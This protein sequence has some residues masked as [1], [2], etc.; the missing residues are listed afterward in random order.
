MKRTILRLASALVVFAAVLAVV[1]V[2]PFRTVKAHHG[3]SARTLVGD[4][5]WTEF[6]LE[7]ETTGVPFWSSTALVHF[8]GNGNFTGSDVYYVEDG[9][10]DGP[11]TEAGTYTVNSA[12]TVTIS[13][14]WES[15]S[16][17]DHGVIVGSNGSEVIAEE[18]SDGSD[19][20]GHVDIKQIADWQ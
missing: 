12:C 16:Y 20:T 13:Y 1:A 2:H 14:T 6:G 19:T 10:L 17:T 3:C 4:Y 18:S 5:G 8:D 11:S 7:P 15:E 9:A